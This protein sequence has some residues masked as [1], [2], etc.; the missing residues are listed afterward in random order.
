MGGAKIEICLS[1]NE[2][3]SEGAGNP[4]AVICKKITEKLCPFAWQ[5]EQKT[6]LKNRIWDPFYVKQ[7]SVTLFVNKF[8]YRNILTYMHHY[9]CKFKTH[10]VSR[11]HV[12]FADFYMRTNIA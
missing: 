10:V 3:W 1:D 11:T 5:I 4:S 2:G 6:V 7:I 12:S 8:R 9:I